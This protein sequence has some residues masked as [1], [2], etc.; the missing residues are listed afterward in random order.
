[1]DSIDPLSRGSRRK[2]SSGSEIYRS[3]H[4]LEQLYLAQ[5]QPLNLFAAQG[6]LELVDSDLQKALRQTRTYFLQT[7]LRRRPTNESRFRVIGDGSLALPG[8][9]F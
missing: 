4:Q 9:S 5:A 7:A 6:L 2:R 3:A 8:Q 1:M